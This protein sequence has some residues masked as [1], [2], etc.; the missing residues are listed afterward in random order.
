MESFEIK[1]DNIYEYDFADNFILIV[2]TYED[3]MLDDLLDFIE[4]N[5]D[6]CIGLAGSGN[7]NFG[8]LYVFSVKRLSEKYNIP[9]LY[10]F[11]NNG[12]KKDIQ[13]FK[14]IIDGVELNG[15]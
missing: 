3:N 5:H 9:I 12:T 4:D 13:R 2:P 8:E 1:D 15:N 6:K 10:D 14:D 7:Y 11:E